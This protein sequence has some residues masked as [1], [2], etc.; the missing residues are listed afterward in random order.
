MSESDESSEHPSA[1]HQRLGPQDGYSRFAA[2]I[3]PAFIAVLVAMAGQGV[4]A[5]R[6]IAVL[7]HSIEEL[8]NT[9]ITDAA[10]LAAIAQQAHANSIH[11]EEHERNAERWIDKIIENERAILQLQRDS[12]ARDDSFTGA[13]GDALRRR[14]EQ[15][16]SRGT[17]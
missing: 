10:T 14:I 8:A 15:L 11:R 13:Q 1:H 17:P 2:I 16:E 12:G 9:Y 6:D 5:W 4:L 7:N 3:I